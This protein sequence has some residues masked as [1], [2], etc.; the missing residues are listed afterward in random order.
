M[1][2]TEVLIEMVIES[3]WLNQLFH[4]SEVHPLYM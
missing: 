2:V 3:L 4:K 1:A